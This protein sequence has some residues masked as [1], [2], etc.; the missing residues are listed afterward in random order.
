MIS[1][2]SVATAVAERMVYLG[3]WARV[4][5]ASPALGWATLTVDPGQSNLVWFQID[6]Q[7]AGDVSWGVPEEEA[8]A[9]LHRVAERSS[10]GQVPR[11]TF[12]DEDPLRAM[13]RRP[14]AAELVGCRS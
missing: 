3:E 13:A 10:R 7:D 6:L 5:V 8:L 11:Q 4:E 12:R 14:V 2:I 9:V 1:S